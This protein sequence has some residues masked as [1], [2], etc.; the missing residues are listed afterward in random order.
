MAGTL[1]ANRAIMERMREAVKRYT[2]KELG[3]PTPIIDIYPDDETGKFVI[4][5]ASPHF[6]SIPYTT[7]LKAVL[8]FLF[9]D[10]ATSKEDLLEISRIMPESE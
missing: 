5:V 3:D 10:P 6:K 2:A 1:I 8:N 9:S 7:R 4:V